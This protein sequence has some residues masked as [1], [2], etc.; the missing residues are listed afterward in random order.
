[1][2]DKTMKKTVKFITF[3]LMACL[4]LSLMAGCSV[5]MDKNEV[6]EGYT[7]STLTFCDGDDSMQCVAMYGQEIEITPPT[8]NGFYLDGYYDSP[9]GGVKYFGGDGRSI[10]KWEESF[11]TTLYARWNDISDL[12]L[13][14][15]VFGSDAEDGGVSGQRTSTVKLS[16]E[17]RNALKNNSDSRIKIE[18]SIDLKTGNGWTPSPIGM[19]VKGSDNSGAERHEVFTHTPSVGTFS[20]F[21][22]SVKLPVADFLNGNLYLVVWNTEK[23]NGSWAYPVYYSRN[24][25]LT[26]SIVSE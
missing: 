12:K 15:E 2:G 22:G 23:Q 11:P 6:G 19:Y 14:I 20:T 4:M 21:V 24:L 8:K 17:F 9:D 3:A 13:T 25:V 5:F 16:D 7:Q 1:L 18:Y 26:F 10:S